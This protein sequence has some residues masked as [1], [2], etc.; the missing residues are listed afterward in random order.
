MVSVCSWRG[1][2]LLDWTRP[3]IELMAD[4]REMHRAELA[5]LPGQRYLSDPVTKANIDFSGGTFP[6]VQVWVP[7]L[8]GFDP[9]DPR[10][11][12]RRWV[13]TEAWW[14]QEVRPPTLATMIGWLGEQGGVGRIVSGIIDN[15]FGGGKLAGLAKVSLRAFISVIVSFVLLLYF[16]L[17]G[18][19]KLVPFG[20]LRN[21]VVLQLAA[22][23]M[24]DWFGALG[25][26]SATRRRAP[27]SAAVSSRRSKPCAPT[28][29]ARSSWSP[30]RAARWSAG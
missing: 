9:S 13:F 17:L 19:A 3:I 18:I 16:V 27:T 23:F 11:T 20:P 10:S 15:T 7:G 26:C 28:A 30:I 22:S 29:A 1:Q 2:T 21:A 8:R 24:T 25:R 12:G 6:T 14:A 5:D 4:W